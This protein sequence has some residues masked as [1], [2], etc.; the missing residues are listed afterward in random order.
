MSVS[1]GGRLDRNSDW[2]RASHGNKSRLQRVA[3]T[4]ASR[5]ALPNGTR[6]YGNKAHFWGAIH[7]PSRQW[8]R[9]KYISKSQSVVFASHSSSSY[10]HH[11]PA[12][13][14][15]YYSHSPHIQ[16]HRNVF[17]DQ[18]PDPPRADGGAR[19]RPS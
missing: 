1:N 4:C 10:H 19:T 6:R 14:N 11:P 8:L 17:P 13:D 18:A 9:V 16:I 7:G 12:I 2:F 3:R 15:T 5:T